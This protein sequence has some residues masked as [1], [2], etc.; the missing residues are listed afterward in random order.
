VTYWM[1]WLVVV[2]LV[3][4]GIAAIRQPPP[5][6]VTA[7]TNVQ[8]RAVAFFKGGGLTLI[9]PQILPFW[10][11]VILGFQ[12]YSMLKFDNTSE[13]FAFFLGAILGTWLLMVSYVLITRRRHQLIL[14]YI[15]DRRLNLVTGLTFI[16]LA[17]LQLGQLLL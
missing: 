5:T 1:Q 13:R 3:A 10:V 11:V 12:N 9:N 4:M 15:S 16:G 8:A 7:T 6:F 2:L 14:K 17:L